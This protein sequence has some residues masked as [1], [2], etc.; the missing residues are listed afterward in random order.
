MSLQSVPKAWRDGRVGLRACRMSATLLSYFCRYVILYGWRKRSPER[1]HASP[2]ATQPC[3]A[4][5]GVNI[6][7]VRLKDRFY[8]I[9]AGV[10]ET[11]SGQDPSLTS[12][13]R[14]RSFPPVAFLP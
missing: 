14:C 6:R 4:E 5:L 7:L 3:G 1:P 11:E 9:M 13:L 10:M 8:C 12:G 2:V